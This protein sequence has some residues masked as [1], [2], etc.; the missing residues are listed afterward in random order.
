MVGPLRPCRVD[1]GAVLV[2]W[3]LRDVVF[4]CLHGPVAPGEVPADLASVLAGL[5]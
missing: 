5:G 3:S 2:G 1:R 4:L